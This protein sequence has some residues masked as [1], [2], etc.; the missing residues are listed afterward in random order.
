MTT[1]TPMTTPPPLAPRADAVAAGRVGQVL[2]GRYRISAMLGEGGMGS[3]FLAE[4]IHMKK[5]FAVKLLHPEMAGNEEV[6]ARFR[7]EA[8][9]AAHIEHPNVVAAS[10]FGQTD[11]G[12]FFL[13]LEYIDGTS[14]R[15]ALGAGPL[16]PPR[17]LRIARQIALALERAHAAGIVHRDLKPENVMLVRRDDEADFVKVLDFGVAR[18]DLLAERGDGQQPLT[19]VGTVIGTPE[20][21]AP[22]QA[23][24]ERVV[25]ASD[26]YAVGVILYELLAGVHPFEGDTM[27]MMSK[28]IIAPVPPIGERA[29]N[30]VVPAP[31][32]AV[33]RRLLEKE[34]AARYANARALVVAIDEAAVLCGFEAAGTPSDRTGVAAVRSSPGA[35]DEATPGAWPAPAPAAPAAPASG[36][37]RW[38]DFAPNARARAAAVASELGARLAPLW[39]SLRSGELLAKV[40]MRARLAFAI[41]APIVVLA[42]VVTVILARRSS[43]HPQPAGLAATAAGTSTAAAGELGDPRRATADAIRAAAVKGPAAVERLAAEFPGDP[44]VLRELALAYDGAGRTTDA[45]RAV[46][47]AAGADRDAVPAE[48]VRIVMRAASKPDTSDEAFGLLQDSLGAQGIDALIDLAERKDV[49]SLTRARASKLLG[50]PALRAGAS[51]ATMVMLDLNAATTCEARRQLLAQAREHG[52]VRALAPLRAMKNRRGCGSRG[53]HDCNPCLRSDDALE[54]TIAAIEARLRK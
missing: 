40:P 49:P 32:E 52:D 15:D 26:L 28:H 7:R 43:D 10:D 41:G 29:P 4:H 31:V 16:A 47:L 8:Q 24:G 46:R 19:R 6:V 1:A 5:R 51:P 14:L 18:F 2:S 27:A 37:A 3:V 25:P 53:R 54:Q 17:A 39:A 36:A 42:L 48:L 44:E 21:M 11:D 38:A 12:A 50:D 45:L 22:E 30:V 13:V 20:Y 34:A 23:L 33:A 35:T 9:A